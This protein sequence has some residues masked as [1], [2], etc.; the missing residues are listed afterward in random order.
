MHEESKMEQPTYDRVAKG[1]LFHPHK[2]VYSK[3]TQDLIKLLMD[4]AKLTMYQRSNVNY[5][6][7]KG[8][9]LPKPRE[10]QPHSSETYEDKLA[11]QIMFRARTS[12]K[13]TL[14]EIKRTGAYE[15]EKYIPIHALKEPSEKQKLRLQEKMSGISHHPE[16]DSRKLHSK[17]K[18]A[19]NGTVKV[20]KPDEM[21]ELLNEIYERADWLAEMEELGEGKKHRSIIQSQIAERLRMIKEIEK[22]RLQQSTGN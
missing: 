1:G 12:R 8:D 20:E 11:Q 4:E 21:M 18:H 17:F 3:E 16:L 13:R 9:P 7:R 6:L 2:V 15:Y 22:K 14:D 10:R 5:H 19:K